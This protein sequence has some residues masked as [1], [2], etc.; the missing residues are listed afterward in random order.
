MPDSVLDEAEEIEL[1]DLTPEQLRE[2]LAEGKVYLG[3]RAEAAALNF[4][5]E[6]NLTALR[7]MALRFT[8]ERVDRDLRESMRARNIS[9]PWKSGER[10]LVAIGPSPYSESLIRWTRRAAAARD[11]P[12][13]AVHVETGTALTDDE[14]QHVSRQLALARQLGAEVVT[15]SGES[16]ADALLRAARERNVTQL[17]VGKPMQGRWW[18]WLRGGSLLDVLL[19]ESGDIE[20]C[21]V[22]P[23]SVP[24]GGGAGRRRSSAVTLDASGV[25][26]QE[27][28]Q[29]AAITAIATGLGLLMQNWAGYRSVALVLSAR[30]GG[31][32]VSAQ[33]LAGLC[34]RDA[35]GAVLGLPLHPA[36]LHPL[37][38][39]NSRR[40]D[41]RHAHH[42]RTGARSFHRPP[43]TAGTQSSASASAA[44]PRCW[45]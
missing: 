42:R 2:R 14:R 10:L 17:V 34:H 35:R 5:R 22:R 43:A 3:E 38:Q 11:C 30:S 18:R 4:F 36:A 39:G 24:G 27:W 12:W 7:E 9:G 26:A 20:V 1:V 15:T 16:V 28:T 40:D 6:D 21:A 45:S 19:R 37:H 44:R 41:V 8:A 33:P 31:G 25:P 13:V 23:V 32:R 29:V